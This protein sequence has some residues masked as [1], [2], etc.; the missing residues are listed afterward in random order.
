MSTHN[1][2]I[3]DKTQG[4]AAIVNF[5][6]A[7]PIP[8]DRDLILNECSALLDKIP[9]SV[10]IAWLPAF[11]RAAYRAEQISAA[12]AEPPASAVILKR[13]RRRVDEGATEG[14]PTAG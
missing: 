13:A 12:A 14:V 5:S 4:D 3:R 6:F 8:S 9:T 7:A 10:L 2:T 11:A 1:R